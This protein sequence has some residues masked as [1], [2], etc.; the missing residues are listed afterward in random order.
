MTNI[1]RPPCRD[2]DG[3]SDRRGELPGLDAPP[4][5]GFGERHES[6][7]QSLPHEAG[8]RKRQWVL[9]TR[10]R[11]C[12]GLGGG[13][14]ERRKVEA[15]GLGLGHDQ[16]LSRQQGRALNGHD[17]LGLDHA[18]SSE[19]LVDQERASSATAAGVPTGLQ[20]CLAG[21]LSAKL[22]M[23]RDRFLHGACARSSCH[24]GDD[25]DAPRGAVEP[26]W[27]RSQRTSAA[28]RSQAPSSIC[29]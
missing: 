17:P 5:G 15:G 3:E 21:R 12:R 26:V 2:S 14:L 29:P 6:Q 23:Q 16:S 22:R 13:D 11:R 1:L 20:R 8:L 7:E 27:A 25:C 4:E 19:A 10:H 9:G 18:R 28:E 24:A